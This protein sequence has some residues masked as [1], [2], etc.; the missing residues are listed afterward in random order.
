MT[1]VDTAT[2]NYIAVPSLGLAML[3]SIGC[4]TEPKRVEADYGNS[5][6]QMVQASTYNPEAAA[7]TESIPVVGMDGKRAMNSL[8]AMTS[9][10][11]QR[12]EDFSN[13]LDF[14][15]LGNN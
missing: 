8:D 4:S 10:T 12:N 11:E 6:H 5:V 3:L 1:Y 9:D 2:R 14:V 13:I 15:E 7:S